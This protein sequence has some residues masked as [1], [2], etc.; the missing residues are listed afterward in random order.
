MP[1]HLL[2]LPIMASL[3]IGTATFAQENTGDQADPAAENAEAAESAGES[4]AETGEAGDGAS[5]AAGTE[6]AEDTQE[7]A[8]TG[9]NE[10]DMGQEVSEPT[11]VKET[12]GAW[13]LK[14]FRSEAEEDPCQMLQLLH[15]EGG[16][17]IAEFSLV[18]LPEGNQAVAAATVAV[19]LGTLLGEGLKISVDG[20]RQ[21]SY[22]FRFCTMVGCFAQIGLTQDDINAFK[23][24]STAVLQIVP[25]QA[26]DQK[27]DV[28]VSLEG[29]TAAFDN[30]SV[31]TN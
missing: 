3:M 28:S 5:D 8:E 22:P 11:Y 29:F 16:K 9:A 19:P 4:A 31:A 17:P 10:L 24:G 20:G 2:I 6:N 18:R 21:K 26:P 7:G 30:V 23:A 27:V 15:E 12:Y 1:K 13:E 14:C 25:A